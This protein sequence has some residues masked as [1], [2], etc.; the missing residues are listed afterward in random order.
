MIRGLLASMSRLFPGA[1][2]LSGPLFVFKGK[3]VSFFN[4]VF[5]LSTGERRGPFRARIQTRLFIIRRPRDTILI[6]FSL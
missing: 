6:V 2:R 1:R 3:F 5:V 4:M